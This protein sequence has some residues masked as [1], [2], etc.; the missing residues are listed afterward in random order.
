MQGREEKIKGDAPV[1]KVGEEGEGA[2][3]RYGEA[4]GI[5]VAEDDEGGGEGVE[6][7]E[8]TERGEEIGG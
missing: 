3:G 2:A 6:G 5:I 4:V 1:R 7:E 8:K